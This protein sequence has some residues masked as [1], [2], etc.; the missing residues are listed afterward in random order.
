MTNVP[1]TTHSKSISFKHYYLFGP[2]PHVVGHPT[3][4]KLRKDENP[5]F[6]S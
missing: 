6:S 5:K 1:A 2:R 3:E 4:G